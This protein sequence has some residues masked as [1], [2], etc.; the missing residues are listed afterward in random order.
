MRIHYNIFYKYFFNKSILVNR[1]RE[2]TFLYLK[3]KE[4]DMSF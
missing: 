4:K 3:Y 1:V 2:T